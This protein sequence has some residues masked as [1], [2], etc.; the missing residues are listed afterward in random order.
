MATLRNVTN[1]KIT[2]RA[3]DGDSVDFGPG[4]K[5][6]V[7]DKFLWNLPKGIKNISPKTTQVNEPAPY[8]AE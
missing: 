6:D 7:D 5:C 4:L 1:I 2:V 8:N 3:A